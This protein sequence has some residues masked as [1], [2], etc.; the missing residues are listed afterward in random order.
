MNLKGLLELMRVGFIQNRTKS[1]KPIFQLTGTETPIQFL[2]IE[3]FRPLH[4]LFF[5]FNKELL[6]YRWE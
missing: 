1:Y 6:I 2:P 3:K 5:F 4:S